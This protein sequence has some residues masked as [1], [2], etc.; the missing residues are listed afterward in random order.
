MRTMTCTCIA[1]LSLCFLVSCGGSSGGGSASSLDSDG[2]MQNETIEADG[3]NIDGIYVAELYPQNFNLHLMNVG[4]AG[5]KREGD[6]FTAYVNLKYGP[7]NS[8]HKQAIYTGR[9]CP[10]IDDD[11]NK[12]AYIDMQEALIAIGKIS[13]PLDSNLDSQYGGY[14]DFPYSSDAGK[15]FYKVNASFNRMFADLKTEDTDPDD[16]MIKLG[17]NDGLTFPGRVVLIQGASDNAALPATVGTLGSES[18]ARTIPVACGILWK[19]NELPEEF[20]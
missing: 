2:V 7:K 13:I 4:L 12:D 9:R 16:L 11:L 10:N 1:V 6:N 3:S 14:G 18:V 15:Y 8:Y 17:E 5:V 20:K 19:V